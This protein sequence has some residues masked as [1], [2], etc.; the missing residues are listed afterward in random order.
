[1]EALLPLTLSPPSALELGLF[2][3]GSQTHLQILFHV[4]E[5][6]I[7][8]YIEQSP[9]FICEMFES[10][11]GE[12]VRNMFDFVVNRQHSSGSKGLDERIGNVST[13]KTPG[14]MTLSA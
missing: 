13:R 9:T 4:L 1:M 10:R 14:T 12:P 11:T 3:E 7:N 8:G 2:T 5:R 6:T